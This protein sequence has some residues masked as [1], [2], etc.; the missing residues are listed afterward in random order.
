MCFRL[1][2]CRKERLLMLDYKTIKTISTDE[3]TPVIEL[4]GLEIEKFGF[5]LG[6]FVCIEVVNNQIIISKNE[7]T[8]LLTKMERLNPSLKKLVSDFDLCI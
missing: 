6:D 7:K 5:K 8:K 3:E 1:V 4:T 2:K